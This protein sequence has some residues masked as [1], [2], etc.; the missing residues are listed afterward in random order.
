MRPCRL[1]ETVVLTL[2]KMGLLEGFEQRISLAI[3]GRKAYTCSYFTLHSFLVRNASLIISRQ[4]HFPPSKNHMKFIQG[5]LK[6][7]ISRCE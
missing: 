7:L 5:K 3:L 1:L 4:I 6:I 2:S